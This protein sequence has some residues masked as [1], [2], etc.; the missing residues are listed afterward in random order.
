[1]HPPTLVPMRRHWKLLLGIVIVALLAIGAIGYLWLTNLPDP[2]PETEAAIVPNETV[3]VETDP[4]MVFIPAEPASTGF[5][6]YPG[7]RVPAQAYAPPVRAIAEAGYLSVIPSMPFGL[8]V[9]APDTAD[10]IIE[11]YPQI[12]HWVIGGHSLGGAMAAGYAAGHDAIDGLALWAAY[13]AADT[14]L[15]SADL[16]ATSIY[17]TNDGL[18]T[19]DEIDDSR[20]RLPSDTT[21]VEIAGGNH[22]GFGWYGVQDGD[23]VATISREEQQVQ[24][25]EATLELL[26][27][28][29]TR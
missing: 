12:E 18:A 20:A 13:P 7:G 5:I 22:A 11:A 6:L 21:F 16:L 3:N 23:G 2:M 28:V 17:A 29:E 1:M 10:A 19:V 25:V 8:A 9:L 24:V 14:D 4:W 26:A 15:S 27:A